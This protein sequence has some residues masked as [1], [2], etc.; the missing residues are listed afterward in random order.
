VSTNVLKLIP[1]DP[2]YVPETEAQLAAQEILR[3]ALPRDADVQIDIFASTQFVDAGANFR[4]IFCPHCGQTIPD[5][6]W[7]QAMDKADASSFCDLETLAPCCGASL[8]LN[9]LLYDWPQGFAR[10]ALRATN[11][12]VP[13]LAEEALSQLAAV[14]GCGLRV[15]WAHY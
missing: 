10:F 9:D 6:W 4:G 7:Q 12:N 15:I 8:S 13:Q 3:A 2:T 5:P 11:P 14:L 1:T